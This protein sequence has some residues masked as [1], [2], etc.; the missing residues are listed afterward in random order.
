MI[1]DS[2]RQLC[3]FRRL[4]CQSG[5]PAKGIK[6]SAFIKV[7][8]ENSTGFN[9]AMVGD[10]IDKQNVEFAQTTFSEKVACALEKNGDIKEAEMCRLIDQWYQSEYEAGISATDRCIKRL[11]LR[12]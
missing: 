3:G 5:I 4:V 11:Q 12:E 2:C 7:A 9:I 8:E 6:K 10:L 1:L